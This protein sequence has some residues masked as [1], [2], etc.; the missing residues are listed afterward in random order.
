M[1]IAS[2]VRYRFD[3]RTP[4]QHRK[5][6]KLALGIICLASAFTVRCANFAPDIAP[7]DGGSSGKTDAAGAAGSTA[8]TQAGEAG[9][10]GAAGA[11]DAVAGSDGEAGA[12]SDGEAGAGSDGEAGAGGGGPLAPLRPERS[13]IETNPD[14]LAY[15]SLSRVLQRAT[16][17]D[18]PS[19]YEAFALSFAM[20]SDGQLPFG[21]RCDDENPSTDGSATL[22]GFALPCPSDAANLYWQLTAWKPLSVTNRFDLAP[23][24]GEN[25]G[26]QH[27]SFFYDTSYSGQPQ[28]PLQAYLRFE[29]VIANPHPE[30]GLEGCR[31]LV[32][33]W[34]SLG[35]TEYDAPDRRA[36]AL[37]LAFLGTSL[38]QSATPSSPELDVL[39]NSGVKP[40]ISPE[41]FG[42]I[43]RMQL[44]YLGD[45]GD[46][47][48]FE[49]ALVSSSEGYVLR[50]PLTQ[51]LPVNALLNDDP[52]HD[53]CVSELINSIPGLLHEDVNLL[54]IDIDPACFDATNT[55]LDTT[56]VNGLTY[57]NVPPATDVLA[58]LDDQ[59]QHDYPDLGLQG[60]DIA[61]RAGFAGT[62]S[63]CHYLTDSPWSNPSSVSQVSRDS[64]Q[65]CA[66]DGADATRRCYARSPLLSSIFIPHWT[67]VL[68]DFYQNPGGY[69]PLPNGAASTTAIDGASLSRLS[70]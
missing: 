38:P 5:D 43:G 20:R 34:A 4:S 51:T 16:A 59:M 56:L 29:A 14:A 27:L 65:L 17:E 30:L 32:D 63:G 60:R 50:R 37:E 36:R 46:W 45:Y 53:Q 64:M 69:G 18:A 47:H 12:G 40:M 41:H 25:C 15:L 58:Q 35:R 21:P 49:D 6:T 8:E 31:P 66:T 10:S 52:K 39:E 13:V 2:K 33:F 55:T 19:V 11:N 1:R 42:H 28:F 7:G 44:L 48:F 3:M 26:E 23:L 24:G 54:R 57:S 9:A 67:S 62:C 70:P 61:I 22:N 68:N